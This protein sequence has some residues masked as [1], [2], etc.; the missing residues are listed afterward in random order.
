[1]KLKELLHEAVSKE[2]A[3]IRWKIKKLVAQHLDN[4]SGSNVIGNKTPGFGRYSIEN[5]KVVY[6]SDVLKITNRL[7]DENGELI[8]PF[9]SCKELNIRSSNLTSFKNF[10][11]EV[12]ARF[13]DAISFSSLSN[14]QI[15]QIKNW[16]GFPK[17][18]DGNVYLGHEKFSDL[19][20]SKWNKVCEQLEGELSIK[21][22]YE[23]PMLS[24]LLVKGLE[25]ING[26]GLAKFDPNYN[27]I[28]IVNKHLQ[29][30]RDILEC[31]EEL[32]SNGQKEYA[33]L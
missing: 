7:V 23:G 13:L 20:Y 14:T 24:F 18:I 8:I 3:D 5:G 16:E 17:N 11:E 19:S 27:A 32:I 22:N 28:K 10:P 15:K 29:N 6:K 26:R 1:M 2:D 31:Q 30:E 9:K 12:T 25:I 33:K 4:Q 21:R